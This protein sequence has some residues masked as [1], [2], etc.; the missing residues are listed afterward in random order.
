MHQHHWKSLYRIIT[1]GSSRWHM[2]AG[3]DNAPTVR[4]PSVKLLVVFPVSLPLPLSSSLYLHTQCPFFF[5]LYV[6]CL[7]LAALWTWIHTIVTLWQIIQQSENLSYHVTLNHF[8]IGPA[9]TSR[10]ALREFSENTGRCN[11]HSN[12]GRLVEPRFKWI[13]KLFIINSVSQRWALWPSPLKPGTN[14]RGLWLLSRR[15]FSG[16]LWA[17][18]VLSQHFSRVQLFSAIHD[19]LLWFCQCIVL[20]C[21][22]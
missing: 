15:L 13:V 17:S 14:Q 22:A 1:S 6:G 21:R 10:M 8:Q 5:F 2:V 11:P 9:V 20:L 18:L 4:S 7:L 3:H 16:P 12:G 19:I